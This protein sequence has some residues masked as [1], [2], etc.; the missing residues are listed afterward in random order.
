MEKIAFLN[1]T[2][3]LDKVK[4]VFTNSNYWAPAL[5]ATLGTG[6]IGGLMAARSKRHK[7]TPRQR[8]R[9]ILR[10]ILVPSL[11]AG[12]AAG[13]G[14]L[15]LAA[16][17]MQDVRFGDS[18]LAKAERDIINGQSPSSYTGTI[19]GG[20]AGG[21]LAAEAQRRSWKWFKNI[22]GSPDGL[23]INVDAA[24]N[25]LGQYV[26]TGIDKVTNKTISGLNKLTNKTVMGKQIPTGHAVA[27]VGKLQNVLKKHKGL[28]A[29]LALPSLG[30]SLGASVGSGIQQSMQGDT[31]DQTDNIVPTSSVKLQSRINKIF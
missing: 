30:M 22:V 27:A 24:T 11:L 26:D 8:R 21:G 19:I 6:A 7:E 13:L 3:F 5:A 2:D 15:G 28:A 23:N 18:D 12:T 4:S 1:D 29:I 10:S 31:Y 16:F 9:R 14:G 17:N 20:A 25:R